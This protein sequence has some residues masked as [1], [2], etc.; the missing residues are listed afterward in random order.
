MSDNDVDAERLSGPGLRAFF[1][2]AGRWALS[3][4]EQMRLL[5]LHDPSILDDWRSGNSVVLTGET[6]ERISCVLGIFECLAVLVPAE[7]RAAAWIRSPNTA[8][9]F[10]GSS[11]LD[12]MKRGGLDDLLLVRRYLAAQHPD[13]DRAP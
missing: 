5:G 1:A 9:P 13:L 12:R 2:I 11:A 6:L 8:R 4:E 7:T 10:G 3:E